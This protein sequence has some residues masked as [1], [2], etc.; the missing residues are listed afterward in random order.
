VDQVT[1]AANGALAAIVKHLEAEDKAV[2]TPPK[3]L[4]VFAFF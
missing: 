2:T 1:T 3:T 4:V